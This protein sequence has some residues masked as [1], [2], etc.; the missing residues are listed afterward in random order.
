MGTGTPVRSVGAGTVLFTGCGGGFG[1][2]IIARHPDGYYTQYARLSLIGVRAGDPVTADT[3]ESE[4]SPCEHRCGEGHGWNAEVPRTPPPSAQRHIPQTSA[5]PQVAKVFNLLKWVLDML[6]DS[7][8]MK[9]AQN[10]LARAVH[11][12]LTRA[13]APSR[14]VFGPG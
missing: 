10:P 4:E 8:R 7:R 2:Q 5:E 12:L 11:A 14:G 6:K 3:R 9:G 1:N 13:V